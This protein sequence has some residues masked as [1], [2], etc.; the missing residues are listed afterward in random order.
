M[1][2]E[3][4][5]KKLIKKLKSPRTA[6]GHRNKR[7]GLS[8]RTGPTGTP[9]EKRPYWNHQKVTKAVGNIPE[10]GDVKRPFW[11]VAR[12]KRKKPIK[13]S[14]KTCQTHQSSLIFG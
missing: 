7:T 6:I 1:E 4:P 8:R 12:K 5:S 3:E 2:N 13:K 14:K 11:S 10:K 9:R